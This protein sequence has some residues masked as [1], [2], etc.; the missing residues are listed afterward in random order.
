[1]LY[2]TLAFTYLSAALRLAATVLVC[3]AC[4]KYLKSK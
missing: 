1:M 2:L 4:I 3:L